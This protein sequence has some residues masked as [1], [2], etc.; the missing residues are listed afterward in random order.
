MFHRH[1]GLWT[2]TITVEKCA[3]FVDGGYLRSILKNFRNISVD[4]LKLSE[5]IS[6]LIDC[7]RLRTYNC[8]QTPEETA[9]EREQKEILRE[10]MEKLKPKERAVLS[11]ESGMTPKGI[12]DHFKILGYSHYGARLCRKGALSKLRE[13]LESRRVM[14]E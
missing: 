8:G 12:K 14:L 11:L 4:Y 6:K 13:K 2:L 5:K 1:S 10:E 3:I 7:K 9:S